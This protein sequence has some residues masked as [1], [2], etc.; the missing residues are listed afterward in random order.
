MGQPFRL[1]DLGEGIH[2][3][4]V[5]A[6]LV[7]V[8]DHV[9]EG[10]PFIE[11]ETDK[12]RVELP[13][14][15]TGRV[16][17]INVKVDETV[18]VGNVLMVFSNGDAASAAISS[19]GDMEAGTAV[20]PSVRAGSS[21][22][23]GSGQGAGAPTEAGNGARGGGPV[24]ASPATRRLA[25]ELGVDLR[26][27]SPSGPA[28]L[29]SAEDVRAFAG[30]SLGS[31]EGRKPAASASG[32]PAVSEPAAESDSGAAGPAA[33]V[34]T[35]GPS[36]ALMAPQPPP[37]PDFSRWGPVE[38]EPLKSVRRATARHMAL[39][40]SQIPHVNHQDLVDV[41]D[42]EAFRG[43]QAPEIEAE[44]GKLTLTVFVLKAVV[45]ALKVHPRFNASLD[46]SSEEIVLK[47][48]YHLGV[49]VDT[50]RGL[51]VPVLRDVDRKSIT[52]LAVELVQVAERARRGETSL[53]E[54][55]G[56]TFTITNI[57]ALGGTGFSPIVNYP[58]VAILGTGRARMQPVVR[59]EEGSYEVVPRLMLPLILGF[60]HRVVDGADAAR[61]VR[62]VGEGLERPDRLWLRI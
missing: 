15:F 24:P 53:E 4:E 61:F 2:E 57:G 10:Q 23:A 34:P 22:E 38:R 1:P 44:G 20:A 36:A 40:W 14:P 19:D 29:V 55:Q 50:D 12:A 6:I 31:L 30:G 58:E 16:E 28:G 32:G 13:S 35:Y 41:T 25:R 52:E 56:G 3:A 21:A 17:E 46:P 49:A 9:E 5:V 37:L 60:D 27:V 43:A 18:R 47:R 33:D 48:Y 45:A 7:K 42:L 54:M 11:V 39:A 26:Q 51:V 62:M 8:G 59:G